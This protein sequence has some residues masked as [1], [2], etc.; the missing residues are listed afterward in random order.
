MLMHIKFN[1]VTLGRA[2]T[3]IATIKKAISGDL[4]LFQIIIGASTFIF[5][6]LCE[7]SKSGGA[8]NYVLATSIPLFHELFAKQTVA[9]GTCMANRR[10]LPKDLVKQRLPRGK[11]AAYRDGALLALKWRD[12]RDVLVLSTKHTPAMQDVSVRAP[13][14]RVFRRKPILVEAYNSYMGGVDK[15]NQL[16]SY[17]R[18]NRKT[19]KWWK[20]LFFHLLS[21]A[22]VNAQK[23]F[24]LYKTK[25]GERPFFFAHLH[26]ESVG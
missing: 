23:M 9:V 5:C 20:K 17:Y 15:S 21:L 22:V 7:C 8:I 19:N 25:Q 13:G 11:V 1:F 16:L 18:F 6:F 24:N 12:K 10:G 4:D 26:R 2:V 14:G 3:S